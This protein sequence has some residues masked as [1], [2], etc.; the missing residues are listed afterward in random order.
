[1]NSKIKFEYDESGD[2]L[3]IE[4]GKPHIGQIPKEL[5]ESIFARLNPET[6][7]IECIEITDFAQRVM[8]GESVLSLPVVASFL[9][10]G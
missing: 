6:M 9:G 10:G 4:V 3:R 1:M 2:I 7:D 8:E 5:S